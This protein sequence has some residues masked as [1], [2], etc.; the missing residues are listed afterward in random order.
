LLEAQKWFSSCTLR[1]LFDDQDVVKCLQSPGHPGVPVT[2]CRCGWDGTGAHLCHRCGKVPGQQRLYVPTFKFSLAGV[3]L[4]F[5]M[6]ETWGCDG[7]WNQLSEV[8]EEEP[9]PMIKDATTASLAT[10]SLCDR[11][12]RRVNGIHVPSQRLG[13]IPATPCD[14]VFATHGGNMT[15]DNK[16]PWMA[17]V[18][19]EPLRKKGGDARRFATAKAAYTTA[20]KASPWM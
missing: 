8:P 14:R 5:S 6:A 20:R 16:K 1:L 2:G 11:G 9:E 12:F 4:K 19:G 15:D 13:M 7:C 3:Q 18:D 10:C 17:Y